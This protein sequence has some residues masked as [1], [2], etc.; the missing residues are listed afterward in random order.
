[1]APLTADHVH[2]YYISYTPLF[3]SWA[4]ILKLTY[5]VSNPTLNLNLEDE[6]IYHNSGVIYDV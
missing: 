1:M 6:P 2:T 3:L 4:F 5:L